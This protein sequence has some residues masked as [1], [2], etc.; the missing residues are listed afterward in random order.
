MRQVLISDIILELETIVTPFM[1][2]VRNHVR[3]M[4]DRIFIYFLQLFKSCK[5]QLCL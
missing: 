2:S 3:L 5:S 1:T 4:Y